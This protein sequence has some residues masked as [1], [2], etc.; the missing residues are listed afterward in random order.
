MIADPL[1]R[2]GVLDG[3]DGPRSPA[4]M[5]HIVV[6]DERHD[7]EAPSTMHITTI[8]LDLA[9]HWFQIHGV[10]AAGMVAAYVKAHVKRNKNDDA[11][12]EA[13]RG[14]DAS[15]DAFRAGQGRRSAIGA[16]AASG[17]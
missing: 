6:V 13:I 4:S 8:G 14:G 16:D 9:K 12:A 11:D 5:C 3:V 7:R 15:L 2:E 10:N 1:R 17:T